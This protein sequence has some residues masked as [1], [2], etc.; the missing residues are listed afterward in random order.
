MSILEVKLM[1]RH[2]PSVKDHQL[3]PAH[4]LHKNQTKTSLAHQRSMEKSSEPHPKTK[5]ATTH[6]L[7]QDGKTVSQD[8]EDNLT[9]TD[10]QRRTFTTP[11]EK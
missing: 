6:F 3:V 9:K 5:M 4:L 10:S 1:L 8:T 2:N 7:D 11:Q